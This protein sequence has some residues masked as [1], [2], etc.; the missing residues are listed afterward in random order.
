MIAQWLNSGAFFDIKFIACARRGASDMHGATRVVYAQTAILKAI[1]PALNLNQMFAR[2]DKLFLRARTP[3]GR[4]AE[5]VD[6]Y[7]YESD[8]DFDESEERDNDIIGGIK[9]GPSQPSEAILKAVVEERDSRSTWGENSSHTT[10]AAARVFEESTQ[11]SDDSISTAAISDFEDVGS[12]GYIQPNMQDKYSA[13]LST[14]HIA[15]VIYVKGTAYKTWR[16]FVFF[17]YTGQVTFS[18]LRSSN[19]ASERS[20]DDGKDSHCSPKSMYCL[21]NKLGINA[22]EASALAAIEEHLSKN[23]IIDEL[24]SK[25]T[26]KYPVI[27]EM[28]MRILME[29]RTQPEAIQAFPKMIQKISQGEMPYAEKVLSDV[30]QKLLTT[31]FSW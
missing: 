13:M 14:E 6:E 31:S 11:I 2:E 28:E 22:L 10:A 19:T 5:I 23:N 1:S 16:A 17:C 4:M 9:A 24:F 12:E 26:S 7:E 30:M 15:N 3:G 21:A 29:N 20:P 8:S 18:P 27:Q 25:F